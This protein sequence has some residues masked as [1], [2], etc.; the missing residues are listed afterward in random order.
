MCQVKKVTIY[1]VISKGCKNNERERDKSDR[2]RERER[3]KERVIER[4]YNTHI[5][6]DILFVL[7]H[8]TLMLYSSACAVLSAPL[9][10]ISCTLTVRVTTPMRGIASTLT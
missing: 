10:T 9:Y 6:S 4:D 5:T 2:E 8:V 3:E 7:S 1:K